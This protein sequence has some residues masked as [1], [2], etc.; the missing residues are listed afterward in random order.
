MWAQKPDWDAKRKGNVENECNVLV[1]ESERMMIFRIPTHEWDYKVKMGL[2]DITYN[3][4]ADSTL[5]GH[6]NS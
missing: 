6:S 4:S 2:E 1:L 3:D 5:Q